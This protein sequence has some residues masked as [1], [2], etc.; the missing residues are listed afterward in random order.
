MVLEIFLV[1]VLLVPFTAPDFFPL[2]AQEIFEPASD[3]FWCSTGFFIG[4]KPNEF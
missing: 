3:F 1:M 4:A 2:P